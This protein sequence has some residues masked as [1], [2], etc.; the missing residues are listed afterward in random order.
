MIVSWVFVLVLLRGAPFILL[1]CPK[2]THNTYQGDQRLCAAHI[3]QRWEYCRR[4]WNTREEAWH[5]TVRI[6]HLSIRPHKLSENKN[7]VV[8]IKLVHKKKNS[9]NLNKWNGAECYK[10]F[11]R[12]KVIRAG[13]WNT[14]SYR[15]EIWAYFFV[16]RF[17]ILQQRMS[18]TSRKYR[19]EK[20]KQNKKT[21][22]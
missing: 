3:D 15:I 9:N 12:V 5:Q 20:K 10:S 22:V 4:K 7:C 17:F 14:L 8:V 2:W 16:Y 11:R 18:M 6:R 13:T 1:F 21:R 19:Y